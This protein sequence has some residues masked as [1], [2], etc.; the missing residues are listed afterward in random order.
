MDGNWGVYVEVKIVNVNHCNVNANHCKSILSSNASLCNKDKCSA[1]K[2]LQLTAQ[3]LN[4][5][6]RICAAPQ[7]LE[8]LD[9]WQTLAI[10][11]VYHQLTTACPELEGKEVK[12]LASVH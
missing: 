7:D 2:P 12:M 10:W 6:S 4:H 8:I 3:H 5:C 9:S 1:E 11:H